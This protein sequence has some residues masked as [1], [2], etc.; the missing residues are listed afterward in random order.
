MSVWLLE[1]NCKNYRDICDVSMFRH[2]KAAFLFKFERDL[3][4]LQNKLGE[5]R[6]FKFITHYQGVTGPR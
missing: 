4:E 6:S 5:M 3:C 1:G 2:I